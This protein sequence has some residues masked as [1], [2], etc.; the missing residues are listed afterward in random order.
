MKSSYE[1]KISHVWKLAVQIM[2]RE[3]WEDQSLIELSK[4]F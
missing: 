1:E 3:M 2:E 4:T